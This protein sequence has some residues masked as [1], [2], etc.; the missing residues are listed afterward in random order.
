MGIDQL[1]P[2]EG[3]QTENSSVHLGVA[4]SSEPCLAPA[5]TCPIAIV[6]LRVKWVKGCKLMD[7]PPLL[8]VPLPNLGEGFRVRAEP[9]YS[10]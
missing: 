8:K 6:I 9:G 1:V 4:F 10:G 2:L 3:I 5:P 7:L